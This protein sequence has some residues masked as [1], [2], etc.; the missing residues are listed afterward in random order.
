MM[1]GVVVKWLWPIISVGGVPPVDRPE[2]HHRGDGEDKRR[3]ET[4]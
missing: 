2:H 4:T 1:R 3:A